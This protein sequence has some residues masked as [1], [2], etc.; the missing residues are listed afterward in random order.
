MMACQASEHLGRKRRRSRLRLPAGR[1]SGF[2]LFEVAFASSISLLLFLVLFESLIF[3]RR[4]AANLKWRLAADALAY[5][6]AWETFNKKT[7]WFEGNCGVDVSEWHAVPEDRTSVWLPGRQASY[8]L[9]I[10]PVGTPITHWQI[11]TD[12]VWPLPNGRW[13]QLPAP[14]VVERHRAER[15]LFRNAP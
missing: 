7:S 14:Y 11:V 10:L 4:S 12:V 13:G 8:C 6:V 9:S 5:D 2:T 3:C 15:N 1:R